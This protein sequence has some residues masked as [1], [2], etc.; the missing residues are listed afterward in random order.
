MARWEP[1]TEPSEAPAFKECEE[2]VPAEE[3]KKKYQRCRRRQGK[4]L[5]EQYLK[6]PRIERILK[7]KKCQEYHLQ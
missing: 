6:K 2:E 7:V 1:K 3:P 4:D 5:E